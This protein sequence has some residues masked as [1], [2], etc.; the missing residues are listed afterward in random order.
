M[1]YIEIKKMNKNFKNKKV[2]EDISLE[3]GKG[4]IVSILGSSGCGKSTLAKCLLGLESF[5]GEV[6]V[7][8]VPL[9]EYLKNKK[10][11]YVPQH[12]SNFEYLTVYENLLISLDQPNEGDRKNI[13]YLLK[14]LGL[15]GSRN[16]YPKVLSGGMKQRLSIARALLGD[17][18]ILIFDEPLSALDAETKHKIQELLLQIWNTYNKT[19][20][21]ITHDIEEA[22]FL[23]H[24]VVVLESNPGKIRE[25]VTVPFDFPRYPKVRY[26]YQFQ[27]LRKSIS[28]II[29]SES[30]KSLLNKNF[31][32]NSISFGLYIWPGNTPFYHAESIGSFDS[33][34]K[35]VNLI[36]FSDNIQKRNY[37][38]EDKIDVLHITT[39]HLAEMQK[40]YPDLEIIMQLDNSNGADGLI[41]RLPINSV[42][43]LKGKKI[44]VEKGEI[45]YFFLELLLRENNMSISDIYIIDM[46]TEEIGRSFISGDISTAVLWEPEISKIIELSDAKIIADTSNTQFI[47]GDLLVCKKEFYENNTADIK[48]IVSAF[49]ESVNYYHKDELSFIKETAHAVGITELELKKVLKKINFDVS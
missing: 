21:Y 11:A 5:S 41:T 39:N 32:D 38:D 1:A 42:N 49:R 24:N 28:Y 3:I 7:D 16:S 2:L 9:D 40:K 35:S 19:F 12:Y 13:N 29:R 6:L 15:Y 45:G 27:N 36:S 23:S 4:E 47:M 20:I 18:D 46:K 37:F 8:G 26:E 17:S 48:N 22:L 25:I 31:K 14:M 10:I 34:N 43:D 44:A 33:F 30:V